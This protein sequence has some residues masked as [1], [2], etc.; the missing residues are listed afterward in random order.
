MSL[1]NG[2]IVIDIKIAK[3]PNISR[4][5]RGIYNFKKHILRVV[6]EKVGPTHAPLSKIENPDLSNNRSWPVRVKF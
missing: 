2:L 5:N 4:T 6:I 1:S 3:G